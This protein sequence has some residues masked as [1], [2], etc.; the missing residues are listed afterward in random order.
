MNHLISKFHDLGLSLKPWTVAPNVRG[1][2]AIF[3]M[4]I[5]GGDF[6][7]QPGEGTD[8]QVQAADPTMKQMVL[9]VH[10]LPRK[11][12]V[13]ISKGLTAPGDKI[14]EEIGKYRVRVERSVPEGKRHMLLGLDEFGHPFVTQLAS[15]AISVKQAHEIL[16]PA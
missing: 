14:V 13:E 2:Q 3:A 1:G 10:E 9:M 15:P 12:Q 16:K 8:I 5:Q 6:L 7:M 4:N 11:F